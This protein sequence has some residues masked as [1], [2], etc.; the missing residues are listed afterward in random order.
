MV[1]STKEQRQKIRAH[2][3]LEKKEQLMETMEDRESR[4]LNNMMVRRKS[5]RRGERGEERGKGR[6]EERG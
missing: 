3:M 6:R 5:R 1:A 4:R 2:E